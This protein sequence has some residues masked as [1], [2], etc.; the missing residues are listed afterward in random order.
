MEKMIPLKILCAVPYFQVN[1][2]LL[3]G[4]IDRIKVLMN[5]E[6]SKYT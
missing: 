6:K 2:Q 4:L 3:T 5:T 1:M